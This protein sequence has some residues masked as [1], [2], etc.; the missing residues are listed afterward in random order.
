[1]SD[2]QTVLSTTTGFR[3]TVLAFACVLSGLAGWILAAEIPRP[4]VIKFATDAQ[5]AASMYERRNA[6][7]RA[8]QIGVVRGDLWSE[9]AFAYGGMLLAQDTKASIADPALLEQSRMV[10]EQAITHAPHD[11]RLWL[12]LA[13]NYFRSDWLNERASASLRMSYYT[14]SNTLAVLPKR[15]LLATQNHALEDPDFQE[16]VRHDI[17]IAATRKAEFS[18]VIA[19]AYNSASS[20]GRQFIEKTLGALD[21]SMLASIRSKAEDR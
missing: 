16:L 21:P 18:P 10:T 9:V 6:A 15:L 3:V 14:G 7:V 8:A 1:M 4:G 20:S 5:S 19:A 17:Q 12:L 2:T 11:S 13:A